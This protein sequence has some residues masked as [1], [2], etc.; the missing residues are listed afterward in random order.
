LKS[1]S[2]GQALLLAGSI[3]LVFGAAVLLPIALF[4]GMFFFQSLVAI[5]FASGAVLIFTGAYL[6]PN[7]ISG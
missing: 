7:D 6:L 4:T 5:A 2:F 3:A 1:N